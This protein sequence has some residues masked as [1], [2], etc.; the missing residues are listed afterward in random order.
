[1]HHNAHRHTISSV[2][3]NLGVVIL[4]V[5]RTGPGKESVGYIPCIPPS[6]SVR[7]QDTRRRNNE[8]VRCRITL[9]GEDTG[10]HEQTISAASGS[11]AARAAFRRRSRQAGA[12]TCGSTACCLKGGLAR[13]QSPSIDRFLTLFSLFP[14]IRGSLSA[15]EARI[16]RN[17]QRTAKN[18]IA[19]TARLN[20][21]KH[22]GVTPHPAPG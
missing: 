22:P 15:F 12:E 20:P 13:S 21:H 17:R 9:P 14:K 8:R 6:E 2:V 5:K 1:M 11:Q 4:Q 16:H 3:F 19:A 10:R 7:L 18:E